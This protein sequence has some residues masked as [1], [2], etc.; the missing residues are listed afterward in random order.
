MG[1][2]LAQ[3]ALPTVE[4]GL[5]VATVLVGALVLVLLLFNYIKNRDPSPYSGMP[6]LIVFVIMLVVLLGGQ[7]LDLS[8]LSPMVATVLGFVVEVA[9]SAFL[10]PFLIA[11]LVVQAVRVGEITWKGLMGS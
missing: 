11:A 10:W 1:T 3:V 4:H 5:E 7:Q 9:T 6:A 8:S 2:T